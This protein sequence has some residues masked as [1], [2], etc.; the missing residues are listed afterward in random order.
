MY[1][2]KRSLSLCTDICKLAD[3]SGHVNEGSVS[4]DGKPL[5]KNENALKP[6][7]SVSSLL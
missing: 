2:C 6:S 5:E 4:E 7:M 3:S 1:E